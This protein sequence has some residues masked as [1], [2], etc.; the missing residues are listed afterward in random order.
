MVEICQMNF[1][2]QPFYLYKPMAHM[3]LEIAVGH[4]PLSKF[5]QAK[6]G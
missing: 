1:Q 4:Q 6:P 5:G 2:L 3:M